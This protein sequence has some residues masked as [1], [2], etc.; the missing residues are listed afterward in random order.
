MAE[1]GFASG[2]ITAEGILHRGDDSLF[3]DARATQ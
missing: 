2:G 1:K 3:I